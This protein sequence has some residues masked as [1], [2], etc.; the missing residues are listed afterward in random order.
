MA[1]IGST[2]DTRAPNLPPCRRRRLLAARE[3]A[4]AS[5]EERTKAQ[6]SE[7]NSPMIFNL[8]SSTFARFLAMDGLLEYGNQFDSYHRA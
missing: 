1:A 8:I 6:L 3:V 4:A 7:Q 5:Q 2:R